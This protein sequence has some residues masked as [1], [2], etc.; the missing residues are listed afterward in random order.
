[1]WL[2]F[3]KNLIKPG[4]LRK[5]IRIESVQHEDVFETLQAGDI[6]FLLRDASPVNRVSSPTKFGEYCSCGVPVITTACVG[7]VSQ[8]VLSNH[9]G[10]VI[11]LNGFAE[12]GTIICLH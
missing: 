10:Y 6:G 9:L 4:F 3:K 11:D 7:D 1:M 8:L 12:D 2:R 5:R